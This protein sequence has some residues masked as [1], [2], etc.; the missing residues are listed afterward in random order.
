MYDSITKVVIEKRDSGLYQ[1]LYINGKETE[2]RS[3]DIQFGI[4][5][6]QTWLYWKADNVF[7][8]PLSYYN[9]INGW[10]T[11]P[12]GTY[13]KP[14][15]NRLI[16]KGC[17]ECHSSHISNKEDVAIP[18]G[19]VF[20]SAEVTQSFEKKSIIYGIDCQRCWEARDSFLL[21]LPRPQ[22]FGVNCHYG[23]S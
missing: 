1:V 16:D 22:N 5:N 2:A 23:V 10:G 19:A 4:R 12:G 20:S 17:F 11:S 3:F 14:Y 6:A 7:E 21:Y 15:F 18:S 13:S 8:L 9:S